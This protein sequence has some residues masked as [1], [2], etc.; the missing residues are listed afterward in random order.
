[1]LASAGAHRCLVFT[2]TVDAAGLFTRGR[3]LQPRH[4]KSVRQLAARGSTGSDGTDTDTFAVSKKLANELLDPKRLGT[5]GE[6]W[7]VGQLVLGLLIIFPPN[8]FEALSQA[9]GV[10]GVIGGLG[11]AGAGVFGIGAD[12]LSP[13]P[14]PLDD[15][16]LIT[17]GI[18][19][20]VRHPMYAGLL[21][22]AWGLAAASANPARLLL[23]LGLT[24]LLNKKAD[25][26]ETRMSERHSDY[27]E[28][29]KA[30][31]RFAPKD[32]LASLSNITKS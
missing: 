8:Q 19:G 15:S 23:A 29:A 4:G 12:N 5:R 10:A 3:Y 18:Y 20:F 21:Y 17:T 2:R 25:L 13:F 26:E 32:L 9:A 6:G 11:L 22:S 16:R 24:L 14:T 7:F 27:P 31:G 28:Y 1:M 30:V